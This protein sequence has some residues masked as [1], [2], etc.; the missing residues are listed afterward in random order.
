MLL[1]GPDRLRQMKSLLL[2]AI[3]TGHVRVDGRS[4]ELL[5]RCVI[6]SQWIPENILCAAGTQGA[7]THARD[8]VLCGL[9]DRRR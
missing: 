2:H 9:A 6:D 4:S 7:L 8:T 3:Q 5:A 1:L